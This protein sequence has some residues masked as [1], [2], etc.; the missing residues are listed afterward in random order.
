[1]TG[2][3]RITM[4]FAAGAMVVSW[5]AGAALGQTVEFRIVE[6]SGRTVATPADPIM[7]F[8]VQARVVGGATNVG[9]G[10]FGCKIVAMGEPDASGDLDYLYISNANGTYDSNTT[11]RV[12]GPIGSYS[13]LPAQYR[14]LAGLSPDFNG[15][16][17]ASVG[18]FKSAAI[19]LM[20]A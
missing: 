12:H 4:K 14:Y 13:G 20:I 3:A 2:I 19:C 9:L 1:M 6:R 16:I 17:N 5:I 11:N 18:T 8:A 10:D 7:N 15:V